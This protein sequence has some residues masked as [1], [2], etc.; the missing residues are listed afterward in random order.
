[1]LSLPLEV[2]ILT[3]S[4]L[5]RNDLLQCQLTSKEWHE[6]SLKHLYSKVK[7]Y[8]IEKYRQFGQTITNSLRLGSFIEA[9]DISMLLCNRKSKQVKNEHNL[10][11]LPI[12]QCPNL[13][14]INGYVPSES[15][16]TQICF[17]ANQGQ[18]SRLQY[19]PSHQDSESM[20]SYIYTALF[21]KSTLKALTI[22]D[23]SKYFGPDYAYS[24][25]YKILLTQ[26][27]E[28]KNLHN[29]HILRGES[30]KRL[31]DYDP[32]IESC[33][34]LKSLFLHLDP[35]KEQIIMTKPVANINPRLDIHSVACNWRMIDD[36]IQ[37]KYFIQKFPNLQILNIMAGH[38]IKED[39]IATAYCPPNTIIEFLRYV[40]TI[41][42]YSLEILLAK[43][44][45]ADIWIELMIMDDIHKDVNIVLRD[46]EHHS[47]KVE[48]TLEDDMSILQF[49]LHDSDIEL[50]Y[51]NFF[52]NAGRMIRSLKLCDVGDIDDSMVTMESIHYDKLTGI[53]WIFEILQLCPLLE[54]ISVPASRY[55]IRPSNLVFRHR[56]LKKL[57]VFN[58]LDRPDS[59]HFL[60]YIS[61]N[62]PNIKQL[63][64][65]YRDIRDNR[66]VIV[67]MPNTGLDLLTLKTI[68]SYVDISSF[69]AF[70]RL[71]TDAGVS[72]YEGDKAGLLKIGENDFNGYESYQ[73]Y[74]R[75]DITCQNLSKLILCS[76]FSSRKF[77]WIFY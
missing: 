2:L 27:C 59:I 22:S 63:L 21:F 12:L 42:D 35:T 43:Q 58:I 75:L 67:F 74:F 34:H 32:T 68:Q 53:D 31:S 60:K 7:I 23:D 48:V 65:K 66:S 33:P 39:R 25:A 30:N 17:A 9:I 40:K 76:N 8:S 1:M 56:G 14:K 47:D 54:K 11:S 38:L 29:L 51:I 16:W 73:H 64:L 6:A 5:E 4:H 20:E 36:E 18:L 55:G 37:L 49:W 69:K 26:I 13:L 57:I 72:F 44:D 19:L 62:A 52:S 50:P 10:I 45:L 15:I 28:F 77:E 24:E 41:P 46:D 3:F 70:I 71:D 61:M